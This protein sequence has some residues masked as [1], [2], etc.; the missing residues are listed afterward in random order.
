MKM[1]Y[2]PEKSDFSFNQAMVNQQGTF[3]SFWLP[4]AAMQL[5][6][7]GPLAGVMTPGCVFFHTQSGNSSETIRGISQQ[8]VPVHSQ[9]M[10]K[11]WFIGFSE[12]DGCFTHDSKTNSFSFI[13]RQKDP[14]VLFIIKKQLG[15]GSVFKATDGYW[16]YAVRS[17]K[18]LEFLINLFNGNL[19][20]LKRITQFQKWVLFFNQKYN[21]GY[22]V[23]S[24]ARVLTLNDQWL[25]GFADQD[26]SFNIMLQKRNDSSN[27]R[28]R[29]RFY[30]DQTDRKDCVLKIKNLIGGH[31]TA[32]QGVGI[33]RL[34][35]DT[36][37]RVPT[38]LE[39]FN[40][41]QP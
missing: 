23:I 19:F 6:A 11:D 12:G 14:K 29:L 28:L 32:R 16:N 22:Q 13:I 9:N 2:F 1:L 25:F 30:I 34:M 24:T 7:N 36:F 8:L 10:F 21:T 20:L 40:K 37:K 4:L 17:K 38:L 35:V 18:N 15:F 39:Y 33:H 26:G 31:L 41:F 3:C 27:L 5:K